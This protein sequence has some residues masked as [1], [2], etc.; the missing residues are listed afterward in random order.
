MPG[1][2]RSLEIA[3]RSLL[4][5]QGALAVYGQ[6]IAN[7]NTPGYTRQ[8][9]ELIP[10]VS[11][12][13]GNLNWG[14]GVELAAISR[15]R[16][17][18]LDAE[19]ARQKALRGQWTVL[20]E[21]LQRLEA[22]VGEPQEN[23]L[24]EA[25]DAFFSAW[26]AL[27]NEPESLPLRRLVVEE[28]SRLARRFKSMAG[29]MARV[30]EDQNRRLEELAST[31]QEKLRE[32]AD[33]NLRIGAAQMRG[34]EA[35]SLRDRRGVLVE[36]L[37]ALTGGQAREGQ[38][39]QVVFTVGGHNLVDGTQAVEI[40][41]QRLYSE[42]GPRVE[43]RVG[44]TPLQF[45]SGEA[46]GVLE[47]RDTYLPEL[48]DALDRL[49]R[50]LAAEVN[51]IHTMG[52]S[53]VAFFQGEKAS[54][55]TVAPELWEDPSLVNAG[56]TSESGRNDVAAALAALRDAGLPGLDGMTPGS[57]WSG[58][59]TRLGSVSRRSREEQE[60]AERFVESLEAQREAKSGVNLDE[61]L[62]NLVSSER[63]FQAAA[64]LFATVDAMLEQLLNM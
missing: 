61:E 39:G 25:L 12:P 35:P 1:L 57:F 46:A 17:R 4:A 23:G 38:D 58:W 3:R 20:Q 28:G 8:R 59:V 21:G 18:Y 7:V 42:Q 14:T 40:R 33:L 10:G 13:F 64:R 49:A 48:S 11:V 63:A 51:R 56:T 37:V 60:A 62:M 27:A 15:Q 29:D 55:L 24:G 34:E 31:L 26:S 30:R 5:H 32:L 6:N 43:L 52:P 50:T 45:P 16:D 36:E 22:L 47:L 54:E 44:Q 53:G 41:A 2:I 19:V 9:P